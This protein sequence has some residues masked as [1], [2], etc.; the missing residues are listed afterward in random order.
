MSHSENSSTL[1]LTSLLKSISL[2]SVNTKVFLLVLA[3]QMLIIYTTPLSHVS[4]AFE[5]QT[6]R[7]TCTAPYIAHHVPLEKRTSGWFLFGDCCHKNAQRRTAFLRFYEDES[8]GTLKRQI[9]PLFS[10]VLYYFEML[11]TFGLRGLLLTCK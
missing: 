3:C 11:N 6:T 1:H 4:N 8:V 5:F 7:D 10:Y 2:Y 9:N